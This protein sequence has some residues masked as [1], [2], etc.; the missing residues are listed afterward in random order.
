MT[1]IGATHGGGSCAF[2][3]WAPRRRAVEV[4][5][6]HPI[7]RTVPMARDEFGYWTAGIEGT[8][9]GA[10]YM[11]RLDGELERPD[12]ASHCQPR[13]V[14]GPSMVVD[15]ARF[16]WDDG[17]ARRRALD[18][19]IIYELHVG[20]FT[21]GGTFA[22]AA[23]R[24]PALVELGVT[25]VEIMPVAQ[26]PG[27]RNW[28]Y[29]G[30][31]PFAV[32]HSYGGVDGLKS[33]VNE[34]H[35]GGLAVI[36][37]VVYNHLGPEGSYLRDFGPYFT[38]RYQTPWGDSL[39]FDGPDSDG[40]CDYFIANACHWLRAF[41][42]DALRLDAVHAIRDMGARPFLQRLSAAVERE[43]GAEGGPRYLIAESDLNDA[44]VIRERAIGGLGIHAQ[45][46]DDF[47]HALHALLTGERRGYYADFGDIGHVE[48]A[49]RGAFCYSGG[50]SRV[51]RRSHGNDASGFPTGRFVVCSQNHD[52]VGNRMLGERLIR[53]AG[54]ARARL[55]AAAVLL[56]PYI[57]LLFMGE[58]HGE[59]N[60]FLYFVDHAD[61][62]L[63]QSVRRGR[64][65]EFA[66][67]HGEGAP[68]DPL[69][70][71]TFERSRPDW[72]KRSVE[73]G[74]AML[75]FYRELIGVRTGCPAVGP[76]DRGRLAIRR[77]PGTRCISIRYAHEAQPA[78]CLFNFGD[79]PAGIEWEEPGRWDKRLDSSAH[80]P[81]DGSAPLP[82]PIRSAG[83]ILRLPPHGFAVYEARVDRSR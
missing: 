54:P 61:E 56:S 79:A 6:L 7:D 30:V 33:F 25:A 27:E 60:P 39:N 21:A 28:G 11:Y 55:A 18:E 23:E 41:H 81:A 47:H 42:I 8:G 10:L 38:D 72:G 73:P 9:H 19:Y 32:Q 67:F 52:Q 5:L 36:L 77:H 58:E 74:A 69:D 17:G 63:K 16:A 83:T 53:L 59:E 65:E 31:Y 82:T 34:C 70:P 24:I 57:P 46:S 14:H 75:R 45:W 20:T 48:R 43:F 15:H 78:L 66:G 44:R 37:D 13:G 35:R 50:Y 49:L 71:L 4:R 62:S 12:P 51:R 3:V 68:P 1:G 76:R 22:S 64:R 2:R 40:V 80:A 29:D 26:F